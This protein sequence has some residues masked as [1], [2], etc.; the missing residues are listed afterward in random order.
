VKLPLFRSY[1]LNESKM[2]IQD[3][4][5]KIADYKKEIA[6]LETHKELQAKK[7]EGFKAFS[8]A[9]DQFCTDYGVSQEELFLSQSDRLLAVI[10]LLSK[11]QP[12]PDLV[13]DLKAYFVRLA[14]RE[15]IS[16]K[17]SSKQPAG[18]RLAVG[19][20]RN[21]NTGESIEKIKRNP[22][23]LDL[24]LAEHGFAKVQSWK[25]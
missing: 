25:V 1:S 14:Q 8:K 22:K 7:V 24:W 20:Y 10:K 17:A 18:P 12:R 3:I 9:I 11:R 2:F 19:T 23:T 4:D 5:Q 16:K 15:G 13:A 21:P 6:K